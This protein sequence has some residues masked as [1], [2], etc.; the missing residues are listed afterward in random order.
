[1]SI[2]GRVYWAAADH[3]Q[4]SERHGHS[5]ES[6][7]TTLYYYCNVPGDF[8]GSP[9]VTATRK[10]ISRPAMTCKPTDVPPI[11]EIDVPA[12]L[13][14][15]QY[16]RD[17]R[18]RREG[19]AQYQEPA[20][21]FADIYEAD[22][23]STFQPRDAISEELDVAIIGGGFAGVLAAYHLRQ[24]GVSTFRNIE[25]AGDFGGAWYWN[26][27]PGVE[28]DNDAYC[29]LPL[30]EEMGFMP[31]KQFADGFEIC[32]YIQSIAREFGLYDNALFQTRVTAM[33]WDDNIDRWRLTTDRGDDIRARFVTMAL[34]PLNKPKLAGIPGLDD[35]QGKIFHTA[36]WDY[37]Y[38][39]GDYKNPVLDKLGDKRV[40]IIGTGASAVQAVPY[41]GRYARQL[42]VIQRT[43]SCVDERNNT[44]TDPEWVKTL[45]PGW[46]ERRLRNYQNGLLDGLAP[47]EEDL[48]CDIWTELNRNLNYELEQEGWPVLTQEEYLARLD[49]LDHRVM[50]RLR[51]RVERIVE[52]PDTAEALK[53]YYRFRC[54]RPCSNDSFY[55]TFN[56][57][58]VQL[59]DVSD[60]QGV[61]RLTTSGFVH[62]GEHYDIDCLI[63]ASGYEITSDLRRRWAIDTIE[64][65][66]GLSIY[67]HW[68]DG[69]KTLHGVAS[70]G[71]PNQFYTGFIQGG[72][73]VSTTHTFSQQGRHIAYIISEALKRGATVVEPTKAAQDA[74][75]KEI[76]DTEID[77]ESFARECTPGYYNNE[78]EEKF[79]WFLGDAYGP[80]PYAFLD[81]LQAWRDEGNLAG[82]W[83]KTG[84]EKVEKNAASC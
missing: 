27:Y 56:R 35:F 22:L 65:R 26:R 80:G 4:T 68:E 51:R 70:H 76:H 52:D 16:E 64:G 75:V 82:L 36:R 78:G 43:P 45:E 49:A 46:Q 30:L 66:G 23:Y 55:P 42:Y 19:Q 81:L 32:E 9:E 1:M 47:G 84:E 77:V 10:S 25:R 3:L 17:R 63:L 39:G 67:D 11:D 44:K 79:R 5:I 8:L 50:E 33:R 71:F 2:I 38:T 72:V 31:S 83:L 41:L 20:G 59:L 54:K 69:Y 14:K 21:N 12:I 60:T 74:W 57:P 13:E 24:A 61:E 48:C 73:H 18:I 40:A 58:N 29:Y 37:D 53:P 62:R 28:C 15:Y 7:T 6:S 34:G